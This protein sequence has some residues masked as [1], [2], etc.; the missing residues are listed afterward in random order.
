VPLLC[1]TSAFALPK[2]LT[3]PADQ[4]VSLGANVTEVTSA[5]GFAPLSYQWHFNDAA[6]TGA[7]ARTLNLTNAQLAIA[8]NYSVVVADSTGSVTSRVARLEVDPTFTMITAG[9]IATDGGA[10]IGAAW[11][12]YNSDSLPDLLIGNVTGPFDFLYR[13]TGDGTF[14]RV[15]TNNFAGASFGGGAWVDYDNDSLLD[16]YT[17]S[18]RD[19][20]VRLFH[21]EGN[22]TLLRL[23]NADL[24]GPIIGQHAPSGSVAVGDYDRD[25]FVDI[26][27]A[28]GTFSGDMKSFLFHNERD[29]TFSKI[30]NGAIA[31]DLYESWTG[32]W[33]DYDDD[34]WPDLFVTSNGGFTPS[35]RPEANRFYHN[36]GPAGFRKLG[37][38]ETGISPDD[39]GYSRGCAWGDY[40]NDGLLDLYVAG[41]R[42][43]LY[44]NLG[45][46]MFEKITTGQITTDTSVTESIGCT[47][48]D[49]DNDGYLDLFVVNVGDNNFFYHNN[50]NGT[51]TKITS[52]SF[53]NDGPA[54]TSIDAAWADYDNNGFLDLIIVAE[55][56]GNFLFHNNGK[57][58]HWIN[59]RLVGTVSNRSAIGAKV[60]LL[61]SIAGK[62]FWQR[63]DIGLN[64]S[65]E[66]Q[67]DLRASFGLGDAASIPTVRVEWPS[68][69]IQEFHHIP[70][71]QFLTVTEPAQVQGLL[72]DGQYEL[73]LKG[74]I[75]FTYEV[76][77]SA[78]LATWTALTHVL[79]TN[80]AM[81]VIS[82]DTTQAPKS[83]FRA[84]RQ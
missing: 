9:P 79:T 10:S 53:V 3:Q 68:G 37:L 77:A 40:D 20:G 66:G 11:G 22:G 6:I 78:D 72:V 48:V 14:E 55:N 62:T 35:T 16:L 8:G 24:V 26:F 57:T 80:M 15:G 12:D 74:G 61:T 43:L 58:N 30:T 19:S 41:R 23:T 50:G 67:S 17:V 49:Y 82:L 44:H 4:S 84:I 7:T 33:V 38:A 51:F 63:R 21:N 65:Q 13:N 29:G 83:F 59:I 2:F 60:R 76:Q 5:S 46:G 39:G 73:T 18:A 28:N 54:L 36:D 52:G 47:W 71:D 45:N 31:N 81:P 32:S 34:G 75:G 56:G 27:V 42:N 69:T 70:G 25:G 64:N 1:A